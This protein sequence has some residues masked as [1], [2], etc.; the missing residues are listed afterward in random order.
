MWRLASIL[1]FVAAPVL[2]DGDYPDN[3]GFHRSTLY[4]VEGVE[5]KARCDCEKEV[6]GSF[7]IEVETPFDNVRLAAIAG[8]DLM[9]KVCENIYE[10]EIDASEVS[11][12]FWTSEHTPNL[13]SFWGACI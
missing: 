10:S 9:S 3:R 5:M 12:D 11:V 13:W 4:V 8:M 7:I 2:A 6:P 1:A